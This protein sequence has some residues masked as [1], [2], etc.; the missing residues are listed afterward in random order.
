MATRRAVKKD[1]SANVNLIDFFKEIMEKIINRNTLLKARVQY[2][3]APRWAH[4]SFAPFVLKKERGIQVIDVGKTLSCMV[5]AGE[6]MKSLMEEGKKILFLGSKPQAH[7]ALKE[8]A[9]R[10][11]LPYVVERWL[12]GTLTNFGTIKKVLKKL[13]SMEEDKQGDDYKHLTKREKLIRARKK[14]KQEKLLSGLLG[15]SRLPAALFVV[16]I[17]REMTA[18]KEAKSLGIRVIAIAD[19]N[20][21]LGDIDLAIP[22]NDDAI[23]SIELIVQYLEGEMM[24]GKKTWERGKVKREELNQMNASEKKEVKK[25]KTKLYIK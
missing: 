7:T 22:A 13:T 18:I 5:K 4:P 16:D 14:E 20:A 25:Q 3:H 8:S 21:P 19:S 10:L 6:M 12:G 9:T 1:N 2:G 17:K 11:G 24:Q 23:S 15:M